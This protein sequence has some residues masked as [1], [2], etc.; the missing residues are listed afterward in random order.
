MSP[1]GAARA[2]AG[3]VQGAATLWPTPIKGDAI[4]ARNR[5]SSRPPHSQHHDGVTLTDWL[6]LHDTP[7]GQLNPCFVEWLMGYPRNWTVL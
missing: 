3:N 6:W 7:G 1:D 5:T 4:G 2:L